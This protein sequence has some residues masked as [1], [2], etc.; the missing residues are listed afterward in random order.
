MQ[1]TVMK[2]LSYI[3]KDQLCNRNVINRVKTCCKGKRKVHFRRSSAC[4][5]LM[6]KCMGCP[7]WPCSV[8]HQVL[9]LKKENSAFLRKSGRIPCFPSTRPDRCHS[10]QPQPWK[11]LKHRCQGEHPFDIYFSWRTQFMTILI[12]SLLSRPPIL[13]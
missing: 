6:T 13:L 2:Y 8:F 3:M 11:I 9:I 7:F 12:S 1:E 10:L 4:D 5:A